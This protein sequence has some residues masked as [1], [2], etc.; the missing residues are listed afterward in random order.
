MYHGMT[1]TTSFLLFRKKKDIVALTSAA[2]WESGVP[3][4][5]QVSINITFLKIILKSWQP[6]TFSSVF[7]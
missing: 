3:I 1:A 7:V 2:L 5:E 6:L 4:S